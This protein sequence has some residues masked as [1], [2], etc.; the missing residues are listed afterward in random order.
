MERI[1]RIDDRVLRYLT[2]KLAEE[3]DQETIDREKELAVTAAAAKAEQA[4]QAENAEENAAG[5]N[6]DENDSS[7]E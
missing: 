4:A 1:F 6:T 2:V 5:E 3:I 7:E